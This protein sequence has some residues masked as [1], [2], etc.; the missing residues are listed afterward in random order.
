MSDI[1]RKMKELIDEEVDRRVE[2]LRTRIQEL[3]AANS[4]IFAS[5]KEVC[6]E[7]SQLRE[8]VAYLA[9]QVPEKV[10]SPDDLLEVSI[11]L[12]KQYIGM[13]GHRGYV[14]TWAAICDAKKGDSRNR[15]VDATIHV[16]R[17]NLPAVAN[18]STHIQVLG[19]VES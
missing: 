10:N 6:E 18:Y 2:H 5:L 8:E 16:R 3:K 4:K 14:D 15:Y 7:R 1:E 19:K 13:F 9:E 12:K 17:K 11:R